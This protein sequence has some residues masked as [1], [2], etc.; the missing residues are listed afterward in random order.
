MA[1]R[2][3]WNTIT[4]D[5][6]FQ[7]DVLPEIDFMYP[8]KNQKIKTLNVSSVMENSPQMNKEKFGLNVSA[9]LCERIWNVPQ[10]RTHSISVTFINRIKAEIVFA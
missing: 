2:A 9:I 10:Q 7:S 5:E 3:L 6:S 4:S 8:I 1:C